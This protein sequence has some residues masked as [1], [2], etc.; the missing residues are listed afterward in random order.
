MHAI[1][2]CQRCTGFGNYQPALIGP[3]CHKKIHLGIMVQY[4]YSHSLPSATRNGSRWVEV[5]PQWLWRWDKR[6]NLPQ[7]LHT[8]PTLSQ[9]LTNCRGICVPDSRFDELASSRFAKV[10]YWFWWQKAHLIIG[11]KQHCA[12]SKGS[13]WWWTIWNEVESN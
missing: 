3:S 7:P 2:F 11:F 10:T 5:N 9:R 13:I 6:R 12:P 1:K 8:L 4:N